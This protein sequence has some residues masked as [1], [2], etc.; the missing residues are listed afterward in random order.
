MRRQAALLKAEAE[1]LQALGLP[2][3]QVASTMAGRCRTP[4]LCMPGTLSME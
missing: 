1:H 2:E 4:S 3:A